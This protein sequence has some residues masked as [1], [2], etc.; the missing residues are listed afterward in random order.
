MATAGQQIPKSTPAE[1]NKAVA[2]RRIDAFHV[3]MFCRVAD[4]KIVEWLFIL[5]I[6]NHVSQLGGVFS[7]ASR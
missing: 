5:D 7:A 3:A 6:G 2:R 4:G 1:E